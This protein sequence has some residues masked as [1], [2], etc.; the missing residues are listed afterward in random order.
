MA[1]TTGTTTFNLDVNDLIEEAFERCG[2]ELR[3]GYDFRTARR[4]L[5]LL[6][7]EWANR[8]LNLWTVEQGIIPMVTG[9]AMYPIPVDTIDLMDMVIRQNNGTQ[10]QID[11]NI[12]RIA[13]PTYMSLPNKLAQGRPIQ[14]YYNR[15]S[16]QENLT[17]ITLD[18]DISATDTTITLSSINGLTSSGFIKIGNETISY[19]NVDTSTN[20]LI[21]CARGQNN[22]TAA[23]HSDGATITV[24]NLPCINV[25]PTPNA[26]GN[27]YTFV[28]YRLRRIQDAGSGVYV[29]DIPFRFIP[30]MVA[31]LAYQL[32]TKLPDMD[33]NRIPMLKADYE[34]QFQL[35]ADEDRDK[36]PVRF[37][38]RMM[39]YGGG[40][41]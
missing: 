7:I 25:W 27:Q 4:S 10:N 9:Q 31:G 32:S 12:S 41:R 26:P 39:F 6:T 21:N 38:P 29:Q 15:Q 35:A 19:P 30:A 13:E 17:D 5:N 36:A 22:T 14:V 33:M 20:Q 18:G 34:Q 24:Q 8:G 3:S 37:V 40:G 11:I 2:K 28:Y 23:A 16:G 1:R